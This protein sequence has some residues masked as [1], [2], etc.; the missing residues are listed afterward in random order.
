MYLSSQDS[1]ELY[2]DNTFTDFYVEMDREYSFQS[3]K[4]WSFALADMYLEGEGDIEEMREPIVVMC[5]LASDSYIK[6]RSVPILRY[7]PAVEEKGTSLLLPYYVGVSKA[8]TNRIRITLLDKNLEGLLKNKEGRE[9]YKD[10]ILRC[11]LH[12]TAHHE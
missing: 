12:F 6:G 11:T 7:V 10:S 8:K 2:P 5:D 3:C 1:I 4:N 9:R